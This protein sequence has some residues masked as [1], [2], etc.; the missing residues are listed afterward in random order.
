MKDNL[1]SAAEGLRSLTFRRTLLRGFGLKCPACGLG[2]LFRRMFWM[3]SECDCCRFRFERPAG[4]FL[5]SSYI[6]YGVTAFTITVTYVVL[7]FGFKVSNQVLMPGLLTF[8]GIFPLVFFRFARSLW[9][10][11]DCLFDRIGALEA[12]PAQEDFES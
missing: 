8:C 5:G 9:L 3:N 6:N 1:V 7:H 12:A 10:S 11:F 2:K 4:Y